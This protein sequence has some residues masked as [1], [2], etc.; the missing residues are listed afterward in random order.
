MP[1]VG[2]CVRWCVAWCV[3]EA[4]A[5]AEA[6]AAVAEAVAVVSADTMAHCVLATHNSAIARR[7]SLSGGSPRLG[8][9]TITIGAKEVF[10]RPTTAPGAQLLANFWKHQSA[11]EQAAAA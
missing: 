2:W 7:L 9:P 10:C 5:E 11:A 6:A 1:E 8:R 4:V 3:A